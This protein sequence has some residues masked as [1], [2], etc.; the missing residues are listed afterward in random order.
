M[1]TES[2]PIITMRAILARAAIALTAIILFSFNG[3][4]SCQSVSAPLY[5]KQAPLQSREAGN[6]LH[7]HIVHL[8]CA[9]SSAALMMHPLIS[10]NCHLYAQSTGPVSAAQQ[11]I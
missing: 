6:H 11:V 8:E 5:G 4:S 7:T 10:M 2:R 9:A 1:G 3:F